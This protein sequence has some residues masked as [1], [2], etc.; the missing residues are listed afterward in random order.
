M[1][2]TTNELIQLKNDGSNNDH[3][4]DNDDVIPVIDN[5]IISNTINDNTNNTK[6][7]KSYDN[8]KYISVAN[9]DDNDN[10]DDDD[11]NAN[12]C[13]VKNDTSTTITLK[14]RISAWVSLLLAILSGSL[15]GPAFKYMAKY[16]IPPIL[17]A[18]W[19]C[20]T[21]CIFLIPLALLE[22]CN[23]A[24]QISWFSINPDLNYSTFVHCIIAGVAWCLNL[25]FWVEGLRYTSTVR[26]S[27]ICGTHPLMLLLY[28]FI[29]GVKVS[30]YEWFGII[31][32]MIG[33]IITVKWDQDDTAAKNELYGDVFCLLSSVAEVVVI[34]NRKKTKVPLFQYSAATTA[35]VA[36]L[37]SI[38]SSIIE[39][40]G[41]NSYFCLENTCV[42]GWLNDQWVIPM[43][44]FGFVVGLICITGFNY[45][46][47]YVSVL[48]FSASTLLDPAI[49]GIISYAAG[50]EGIPDFRTIIGGGLIVI[51]VGA[52]TV[53]ESHHEE[54]HVHDAL[55]TNNDDNGDVE[56]SISTLTLCHSNDD[57]NDNDDDN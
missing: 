37:S 22:R 49:T 57:E 51:G 56:M 38:V 15:I 30:Y 54:Q 18:A 55:D 34:L 48:V 42:F 39:S 21:M 26:A 53:G 36:I 44:I 3:D 13:A 43:L 40:D 12:D 45:A 8:T 10:D 32:A 4:N 23:K 28:L 20:Q 47:Q 29:R 31:L 27:I 5:D 1:T 19:R 46:M 16:N 41:I 52:V 25:L 2:N 50:L 33:G 24:S 17:A 6:T 9:D 7:I 35:V 11:N 14:E